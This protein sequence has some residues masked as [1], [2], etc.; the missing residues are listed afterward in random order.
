M[1][2][3]FKLK[4]CPED[5]VVSKLQDFYS[6][7]DCESCIW[8]VLFTCSWYLCLK[9]EFSA[10]PGTNK[11]YKENITLQIELIS[12]YVPPTG[13]CFHTARVAEGDGKN[14]ALP[15]EPINKNNSFQ[16]NKVSCWFT[17]S[18]QFSLTWV[19]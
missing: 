12:Y 4:N 6:I 1:F 9:F 8:Y 11:L 19:S 16:A 10:D 14:E 7:S 13:Q 3:I 18:S 17:H 5:D 2:F 15:A